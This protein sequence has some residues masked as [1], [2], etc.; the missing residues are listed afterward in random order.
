LGNDCSPTLARFGRIDRR[1]CVVSS[2]LD[3][4]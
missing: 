3:A 4:L 1:I 2:G